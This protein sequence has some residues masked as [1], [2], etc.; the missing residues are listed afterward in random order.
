[1]S[2]VYIKP[3]VGDIVAWRPESGITYIDRVKLV[4]DRNRYRYPGA[5]LRNIYLESGCMIDQR[6]ILARF[7]AD[8]NIQIILRD[9]RRRAA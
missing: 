2:R 1:M 3:K 7:D 6:M 8:S 4:S 9:S 5:Y